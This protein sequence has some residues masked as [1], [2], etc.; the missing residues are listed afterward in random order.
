MESNFDPVRATDVNCSGIALYRETGSC[1]DH[2]IEIAGRQ[3][4]LSKAFVTR[5]VGRVDSWQYP[6][7]CFD[8]VYILF[9]A[10]IGENALER[11][12]TIP[13]RPYLRTGRSVSV[14]GSRE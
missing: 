5:A 7:W 3:Y 9:Q 4:F 10:W 6:H 2:V 8:V 14:V 11:S 13:S 12:V 1:N